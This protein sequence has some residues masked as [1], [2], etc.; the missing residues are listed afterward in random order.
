MKL[1]IAIAIVAVVSVAGSKIT[2]LDRRLPLGF[3]NILFTGS[4]YIF[5]GILVG[6]MGLNILDGPTLELLQPFLIFGLSWIGFLYG[7]QFEV[8]FMRHL[9]RY[10]FSMTA[11]QATITFIVITGLF[12]MVLYGVTELTGPFRL[13]ISLIVGATGACT[14]QSAIAIVN[15]NYRI[16]N[17]S[18]VELLRY[19][20][21]V[22]GLFALGFLVVSLSMAAGFRGPNFSMQSFLMNAGLSLIIGI[23]P[24][25]ILILLS[26]VRFTQQE[27]LVF[28]V[29]TIMFSG[30]LAVHMDQSPLVSGLVCGIIVANL[31]RHRL[32]AMEIVMHAEKS[33]YIILL[34][35]LGAN[36]QLTIGPGLVLA[37]VYPLFRMVGKT[38]GM[39][40]ALKRFKPRF[41]APSS[42]GLGLISEGGLAVA[43]VL[44]FCMLYP[45]YS[46][47]LIT[48]VIVSI[49]INEFLSPRLILAQFQGAEKL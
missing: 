8:R 37:A 33:I 13:V 40:L 5:I 29:G 45:L 6:S 17:R 20:S 32:R 18:L 11:L 26:R 35:F 30:G 10:Y 46:K 25:I 36:W 28:I 43:I 4:E 16:Q 34:L 1:L 27:F 31:C 49:I 9:P 3:R 19:I 24:A 7:V 15:R 12:Y 42:L 38:A 22:D 41:P 48:I 21:S 23:V 44:E 2:F 14:A 47:P 39:W